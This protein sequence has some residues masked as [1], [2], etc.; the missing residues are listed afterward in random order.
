M[1]EGLEWGNVAQFWAAAVSS[2]ALIVSVFAIF[3][4]RDDKAFDEIKDDIVELFQQNKKT[5]ERLTAV[6]TEVKHLPTKEELHKIDTKITAIG[7]TIDARF[8]AVTQQLGTIIAQ[9]ERAQ[10]RL[11]ERED[12][13]A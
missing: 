2:V 13:R 3:R 7:A 12:R 8:E 10:D 5:V 6:E 11:A 1:S 4:N 9:N